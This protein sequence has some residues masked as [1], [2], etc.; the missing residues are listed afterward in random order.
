MKVYLLRASS[1]CRGGS[2]I[3]SASHDKA[4]IEAVMEDLIT[5]EERLGVAVQE[6]N[7]LFARL[8]S[9]NEYVGP[10]MPSFVLPNPTTPEQKEQRKAE[11]KEYTEA[12]QVWLR[13]LQTRANQETAA[14][15]G[16]DVDKLTHTLVHYGHTTFDILTMEEV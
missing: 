4:K 9:I 1:E 2:Y 12:R 15:Y 13:A 16:V 5:Q 3:H 10:E 7:A 8:E 6:R 11:W 14:K